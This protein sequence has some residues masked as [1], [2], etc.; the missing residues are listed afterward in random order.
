MKEMTVKS[1]LFFCLLFAVILENSAF[2]E[3]SSWASPIVAGDKLYFFGKDGDTTVIQ[4]PSKQQA[5]APSIVSKNALTI[6]SRVYG[7]A[8]INGA[9]LIHTG[10]RLICIGKP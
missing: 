4:A 7:V 10:K 3:D 9:F 6:E 2:Q 5:A 1:S 8:A